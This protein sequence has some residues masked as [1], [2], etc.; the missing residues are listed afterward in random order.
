MR[1]KEKQLKEDAFRPADDAASDLLNRKTTTTKKFAVL[2]WSP[3]GHHF[4]VAEMDALEDAFKWVGDVSYNYYSIVL[5]SDLNILE[6]GRIFLGAARETSY[7]FER[8]RQAYF[9]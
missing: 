8:Q 6:D 5:T 1:S 4:I 7:E 3:F 9:A 2:G